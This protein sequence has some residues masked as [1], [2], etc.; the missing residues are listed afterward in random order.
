MTHPTYMSDSLPEFAALVAEQWGRQAIE[1]NLF[2][3]DA[4]GGLLS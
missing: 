2:L 1:N 4:S 3:R